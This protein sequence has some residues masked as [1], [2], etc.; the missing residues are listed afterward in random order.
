[1][2][3]RLVRFA[4]TAVCAAATVAGAQTLKVGDKAP[5]LEI[6]KWVKGEPVRSFE[7]GHV[8]LIDFW[9][10]WCGPCVRSFPHL[11]ELQK[12]Y[13][14]KLTVIAV[15]AE[16]QRNTLDAVE[17]MVESKSDVMGYTVAWDNNRKSWNAY[18]KASGQNGIPSAFVV[19]GTGTVAW[20]GYPTM[21]QQAFDKVVANTVASSAK[22]GEIASAG[23]AHRLDLM[24]G[25][26]APMMNVADWVKGTPI[27]KFEKGNIYVVEFWAT[28]CGP[29]RTSIPHL[30]ELQKK[31]KS[32]GVT[33][34]GMTSED[35][36]NSLQQVKDM[37]KEYGA[38]MNYTVAWD[39]GRKTNEAFMKAAEQRGIPTAF[40]VD[41]DL[42]VAW[43]GH[44]MGMDKPLAEIAAGTYDTDAAA[45]KHAMQVAGAAK[46]KMLQQELQSAMASEDWDKTGALLGKMI[47][48][49]PGTW[50][51]QAANF[52]GG[53]LIR[54]DNPEAAYKIG[55]ALMDTAAADDPGFLNALAWTIVDPAQ[56]P[57][58]IDVKLALKAAER[59]VKL[60]ERKDAMIMDTLAR[61]YWINGQKREAIQTQR[62][63]VGLVKGSDMEEQ[64]A[65]VLAE[66]QDGLN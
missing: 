39:T 31:H 53:V 14:D 23:D 63:A 7:P 41:R 9:A 48:L 10:T 30:T 26:P 65:A 1:M 64:L 11:T 8:Y 38:K 29:C 18:M 66:Y 35:P 55:W 16:D 61:A 40:I 44:P 59:G 54:Q 4:A 58:K 28:W 17:K 21:D 43:I 2:I 25:D 50:G 56:K 57:S 33:I 19:D 27:K 6:E 52:F 5:P 36:N 32:D 22:G 37:V 51:G 62:E 34:I 13:G 45:K 60:T 20:L 47:E 42:R 12:E 15:T 3:N 46:A 24:V 49:D